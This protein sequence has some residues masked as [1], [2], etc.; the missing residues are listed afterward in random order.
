MPSI[1]ANPQPAT[2]GSQVTLA[3]RF[4]PGS[5]TSAVRFVEC[6]PYHCLG[7]DPTPIPGPVTRAV[8][9][10]VDGR[11][12]YRTNLRANTSF[13]VY[14][15]TAVTGIQV[16]IAP[17]LKLRLVGSTTFEI[18]VS[19][20]APLGGNRARVE[21]QSKGRWVKVRDVSLENR[22]SRGE[23]AISGAAFELDVRRGTR[24]R[25]LLR[26]PVVRT[27]VFGCYALGISNTVRI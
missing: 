19:V 22:A 18:T 8:I 3:G 4:P 6:P 15:D 20:A 5:E 24:I 11:W 25:V 21:R 13:K 26:D 12:T 2:Y 23:T 17:R 1:A 9:D 16:R 10:S 7:T 14:S 27:N